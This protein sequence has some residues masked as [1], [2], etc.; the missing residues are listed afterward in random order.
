MTKKLSFIAFIFLSSFAL[1]QRPDPPATFDLRDVDGISYVT[2][3]KS[4]DGGTCWTH[5][6]MAA[7]EGNLLITGVWAAAGESGEP[8]LAEYHLDWW[9]GFNQ[10]N[11]DDLQPPSGSGLT[12][13]QGGDYMVTSAYLSRGEG[14]VRDI[15]GQSFDIPPARDAPGYHY[16]YPRDI[17]WFTA[18]DNLENINAMKQ[19]IMEHGVMGTCLCSNGSFISNYIHYQPPTSTL[20]PNHAVA[21]VGWDDD[22][23]TQAPLPGAWLCKNS[24]GSSW[25]LDGYFWISYYDKHCG[26]HPEM[27]GI[28][29]GNAEPQQYEHIYYHDY[30]GWRDTFTGCTAVANKFISEGEELLRAVSFFTAANGVE[31]TV[32]LFD[33]FIGGELQNVLSSLSGTIEFRGFHTLDLDEMVELDEGDDFY[34]QLTLSEG[35]YPYDRTSDVPV[36]LGASYRTIVES[37]AS[38]GESYYRSDGQWIDFY[39]YDDPSGFLHTGNFCVKALTVASGLEV[40]PEENFKPRGSMG[41]PFTPSSKTYSLENKG[42]TPVEYSVELDPLVP[43]LTLTGPSQGILDQGEVALITLEV[44]ENAATLS[45]GAY[46]SVLR[47]IRLTGQKADISRNVVLLVG[48]PM[49]KQQWSFETDPGWTTEADWGFGQPTGSG[50]EHGY[51]DPTQGYTQNNVYGYNLQGDYQNN[52]LEKHLT[53]NSI[54]CSNWYGVRLKFMRW[55]GVEKP[56]FDH[57]YVRVSN[58]GINWQTIWTNDKEITDNDWVPVEIDISD[59]ADHQPDVYLRWTMGSTDAGWRYCGWNIDDVELYALENVVTHV[60]DEPAHSF[61][62]LGNHPNPFCENT[63]ITYELSNPSHITLTIHTL[64]GRLVRTLL[65]RTETPGVKLIAWDGKDMSGCRVKPGVYVY[66]LT[67]GD[68]SFHKKMILLN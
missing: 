51:P 60:Q 13:H 24:W 56:Q 14:A 6:A 21:I 32:T 27:G 67:A 37:A 38:Y 23:A 29:F 12:V 40:T 9:N 10:H 65:N 7:I 66:R 15:D 59:V 36:L 34:V 61:R 50:G 3:V 20:D 30:H 1:G 68:R 2:S 48:E 18:G 62:L 33:D 58:D 43:W 45:P 44:N 47:F 63:Q 42:I 11:N 53:S 49:L 26:H 16:Y 35:G 28:S 5:G 22:K 41:G 55:L 31:Y 39:D 4:Q 8:N 25:G 57:A 19:S 46:P 54:D 64:D 52:L 17:E